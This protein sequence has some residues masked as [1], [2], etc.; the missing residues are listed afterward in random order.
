MQKQSLIVEKLDQYFYPGVGNHWDDELFR[1]HV[2]PFMDSKTVLLDAGAGRGSIKLLDFKGIVAKVCGVDPVDEVMENPLLDEAYIGFVDDMPFFEDDLFDLII[3]DNVLEHIE[4]PSAFFSEIFR[5]LK[6]GG[7]F[8]A[9]TPN[10][11]HYMPVIAT[12]T[13][14]SFHRYFNRLRGREDIDTFPTMYRA[15]SKKDIFEASAAARL[16]V[17]SIDYFESRPEYLRLNAI[18]YVLGILYE[19]TVNLLH[20]DFL[21]IL[22]IISLR[23][24]R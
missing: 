10:K 16:D 20:M 3:C 4:D 5:V 24:P 9:K 22:L 21:K 13:P 14:T 8:F 7:Y 23:K 17:K 2:L 19:R 1:A 12:L 6:P 11:F 15:N 18:S